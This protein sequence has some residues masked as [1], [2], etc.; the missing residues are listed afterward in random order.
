MINEEKNTGNILNRLKESFSYFSIKQRLFAGAVLIGLVFFL[1]LAS[2]AHSQHE[3]EA[4][5]HA[6]AALTLSPQA[7]AVV[8][9]ALIQ[10]SSGAQRLYLIGG[11]GFLLL[12][13]LTMSGF[14]ILTHPLGRCVKAMQ[15]FAN[16]GDLGCRMP[17][18]GKNEFTELADAF[19]NFVG[20]MSQI[21]DLVN[22][23]SGTLVTESQRLTNVT[24]LNR[25]RAGTQN[26]RVQ[27]VTVAV[28]AM[29]ETLSRIE[30]LTSDAA[31][32]AKMVRDEADRG[33]RIV[34]NA[35]GAINEV[36]AQVDSANR[37]IG[38]LKA[39]SERIGNIVVLI[40]GIT[41]QTNLLALNAAIEAA[42][43]GEYGRGFAVV[44]NEVRALSQEVAEQNARIGQQIQ[45]LRSATNKGVDIISSAFEKAHNSV[46]VAAQAGTALIAITE[47]AE[48][49]SGMNAHI[50]DAMA[51][52]RKQTRH[53]DHNLDRIVALST[54]TMGIADETAALGNEFKVLAQQLGSLVT[55][56]LG[57]ERQS[58]DSE[59]EQQSNMGT[60]TVSGNGAELF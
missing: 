36:A 46:D 19:N 6:I 11:A 1:G 22:A 40:G 37:A 49:I 55:Q 15:E 60:V 38:E 48:E 29:N 7:E 32:K 53:V 35:V 28:Q 30:T 2:A 47:A 13:L 24:S 27:E 18:R 23:S 17:V 44:A 10:V 12:L 51:G 56:F 16:N 39:A 26:E 4:S 45:E 5:L 50:V 41:D 34:E 25:E 20:R 14:Y 3:I 54:E 52:N 43:A 33:S 31:T 42:R 58:P 8:A 59:V 57:G 21:V 9:E